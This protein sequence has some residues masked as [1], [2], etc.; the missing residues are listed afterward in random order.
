MIKG[1]NTKIAVTIP[2]MYLATMLSEAVTHDVLYSVLTIIKASRLTST[3]SHLAYRFELFDHQ[4]HVQIIKMPYLL[5]IL[6]WIRYGFY[7]S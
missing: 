2:M 5:Y 1:T 3:N 4:Q 6:K 7:V